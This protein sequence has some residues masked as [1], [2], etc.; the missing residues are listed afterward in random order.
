V[1]EALKEAEKN[2]YGI[3]YPNEEEYALEKPQLVKKSAGYG[4][5]FKAT[6][7]SYHIVKVEVGGE[8]SPIIG[9]KQQ[10]EEFVDGI[11]HTY[12]EGQE[13]VWETNI[14]GKSLRSLVGD[15][16][17]GKA[18]GMPVELRKK[19][20]RAVTRIVNDGKGNLICFVF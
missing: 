4:V 13:K 6:A 17:A 19:V 16:F 15:E 11:L 3:V 9:T 2:G 18:D 8:V 12:E 20:R 14:F 7:T 5:R 10:G 1:Q